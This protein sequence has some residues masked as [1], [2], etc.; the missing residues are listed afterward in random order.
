LNIPIYEY[1]CEKCG[2]VVETLRRFSDRDKAVVCPD[3]RCCGKM[4]VK[5]SVV[6]WTFGWKFP[7]DLTRDKNE[8]V[9]NL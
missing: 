5:F 9:R 1:K 6:R 4:E 2:E 7:D 8:V 3:P